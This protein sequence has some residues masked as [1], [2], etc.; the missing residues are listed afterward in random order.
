MSIIILVIDERKNDG[1][2][3]NIQLRPLY[4]HLLMSQLV[5]KHLKIFELLV[6]FWD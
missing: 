3:V 2:D 4:T 5:S 6:F 1:T